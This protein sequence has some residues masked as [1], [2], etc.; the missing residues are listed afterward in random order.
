VDSHEQCFKII[1]VESG[2]LKVLVD[3]LLDHVGN[4]VIPP[5][6]LVLIGSLSHLAN[7]GLSVYVHDLLDSVT[8]ITSKLGREVRVSPLPPM[9]MSGIDSGQVIRE[10]FKLATWAESYF[11]NDIFLSETTAAALEE[12]KRNGEGTQTYMEP[13]RVRLPASTGLPHTTWH[14][15]G[16]WVNSNSGPLPYS[17]T[18]IQQ[19]EEKA[20]VTTMIAEIREKQ[21]IDLDPSP[22]FE[23]GL[24]GQDRPRQYIDFAVVR[25]S[26]ASKVSAALKR[27]GFSCELVYTANWRISPSAVE[28]MRIRLKE[29]VREKDPTTI[30]FHLLRQNRGRQLL[31]AQTRGGR[32]LPRG[33]GGVPMRQGHP[34]PAFQHH[35]TPAGSDSKETGNCHLAAAQVHTGWLLLRIWSLL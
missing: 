2:S 20:L 31:C 3:T 27:Q 1:R 10:V 15:G 9:M 7:A 16:P 14:S 5:D 19:P 8:T 30:V 12:I 23:R 21:A 6:S 26:H 29:V 32:H 13:K 22:A 18:A 4:R 11:P 34:P 33:G 35:Q 24:G 25:S 17:A 28:D